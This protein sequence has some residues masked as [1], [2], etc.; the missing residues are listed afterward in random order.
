MA[1][2]ALPVLC[3]LGAGGLDLASVYSDRSQLQDAADAAALDAAKQLGMTGPAG[4]SA[5]ADSMVRT[6]LLSM[7]GRVDVAVTATVAADNSAVTVAVKGHRGSF[8]GNMFPPGG[9]SLEADATAKPSGQVP[10]CV[11]QSSGDQ[12]QI[13]GQSHMTAANCLVQSNGSIQVDPDA[14]IRAGLAQAVGSAS[15]PIS[16]SA[17]TGAPA[18]PDPFA[19]M[20]IQPQGLLCTP[21]DLVFDLGVQVLAPGIHCGNLIAK[22]NAIVQLL[23]GDHYFVKSKLKL[24]EAATL[25]G[26]NV[27]LIFDDKSYIQFMDNSVVDLTGRDSGPFAGFV[28]A[29]TNTNT[30]TFEIS[31][32]SAHRLLGTLY[33]PAATLNVSG[34]GNSVAD[35]SAW[36][37]VVAKGVQMSG[38]ANLVINAAYAGAPVPVPQGVGPNTSVVLVK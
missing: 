38:S 17:Q 14:Q 15:G 12:M 35:Q 5:R 25:R 21:L 2:V 23:P 30:N 10:L 22:K 28:L 20:K 11:L 7:Q 18:I 29:T 24:S 37:V 6:E 16:P 31:S 36:T 27:A 1:A 8:F 13:G 19:S 9:W 26:S 3:L 4:I 33:M 34:T 32:D